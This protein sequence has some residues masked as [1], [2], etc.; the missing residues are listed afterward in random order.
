MDEDLKREARE[1]K[2]AIRRALGHLVE[3]KRK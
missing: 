3:K 2:D 1:N